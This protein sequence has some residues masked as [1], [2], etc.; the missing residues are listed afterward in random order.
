MRL[1]AFCLAL[2]LCAAVPLAAWGPKGHRIVAT[3]ALQDLPPD[4][5][6]WFQGRADVFKE[7]V[8]EPDHWK[9]SDPQEGPRHYLDCEAYG[10]PGRVPLSRAAA[11]RR[12][13]PEAFQHDGQVPWTIQDRVQEL[14]QAFRDGDPDQVAFRAAILCH[15]V[16]DISV[17]LHTTENYDGQLTGQQGVHK[18]WE[19]GLVERLGSWDPEPMPLEPAGADAPFQWLRASYTLVPGLLADDQAASQLGSPDASRNAWDS[20]YWS[21]FNRRQGPHV[22]EQLVLAGQ[23]TAE[24]ILLAWESAGRPTA[25]G[26]AGA[27]SRRI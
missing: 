5:A 18:R 6:E 26:H 12:L 22:K 27:E 1:P 10:G 14:A 19:S 11:E 17:P 20:P 7:H 23:R 24:M 16:G 2:A 13:G 9:A 21:E 3:L 8:N 25:L 15:Y 4:L